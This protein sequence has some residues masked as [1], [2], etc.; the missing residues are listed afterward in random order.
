MKKY[1]LF[2]S[3][4][5]RR[6]LVLRW[7]AFVSISIF[8]TSRASAQVF[9]A[10]HAHW[11]T[12]MVISDST[13]RPLQ[14]ATVKVNNRSAGVVTDASGHFHLQVPDTCSLIVSYLG[15]QTER[16]NADD[17]A[18]GM[19]IKLKQIDQ[20]LHALTVYTGYQQLSG[21][22]ITGAYEKVGR[23][24]L[25]LEVSPDILSKL[26]GK[27]T[28]LLF[29]HRNNDQTFSIRGQS[30]IFGNTSPLII[31]NDFPYEGDLKN[32][33][34]NDI[35]SVTVLKDA[36]ATS[37]WGTRAGNGVVV[38]KTR[39]ASYNQPFRLEFSSNLT[40]ISKPNV[41]DIPYMT[42]PDYIGAEEML[43][44]KGYY[45]GQI[46]GYNHPALTP[47]VELLSKARNGEISE[48]EANAKINA[49]KKNNVKDDF[50][51]Y[52]YQ[53]GFNQQYFLTLSGGSSKLGYRISGGYDYNTDVLAAT[54]KRINIREE[55]RWNPLRHL[56][57]QTTLT[58]TSSAS[59]GGRPPYSQI[60][61]ASTKSLFPYARLA[62]DQGNPL[63]LVKDYNS[64][65]IEQAE[66]QGLLNWQ[67]Y[68]L[69]DY[70]HNRPVNRSHDLLLDASAKYHLT[71]ALS[72]SITYQYETT[73][74]PSQTLET[75]Q[76]YDGRNLIN[77]FT[78]VNPDGSLTY[79]VPKGD[80]LQW[81]HSELN[82]FAARGQINYDK[83]WRQNSFVA[84]AG[85]EIRQAH[86]ASN[87]GASYGYDPNTLT[88]TS[89]DY[90]SYFPAYYATGTTISIPDY[91]YYGDLMD[92]YVSYY[93]HGTYSYKERYTLSIS[94]RRDGSNIFGVSANQKIVPLWSAGAAW[95]LSKEPFYR[96]AW[97]PYL[98]LRLTNGFSG[99]VDN[100]LSAL[101]TIHEDPNAEYSHAVYAIIENPP[102]PSLRW[103][104]VHQLNVGVDFGVKNDRIHGSV[105]YYIKNENDLIGETPL[106]PTT[107]VRSQTVF[108]GTPFRFTG[109][110]ADMSGYGVNITLHSINLEKAFRWTT[111]LLFTYQRNKVTKYAIKPDYN[112]E[113]LN[114]GYGINP[115]VGKP[116][117]AI[118]SL[119]WAGLDPKTGDPMG[120]LKG[121]V[122]KEYSDILYNDDIADLR[123]N[124]PALPPLFGTLRNTFFYKGLSLSFSIDYKFDN[125]FVRNSISYGSL[126]GS[127]YGHPDFAKRWQKPGDEKYTNVPSMVYPNPYGRDAF[128]QSSSV[129]VTPGDCIRL[130][131]L[132]LS[133][134]LTSKAHRYRG[135][136]FKDLEISIDAKNLGLLW[137]ANKEGLDP[138]YQ[139]LRPS[140]EVAVGFRFS[141]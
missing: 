98:K 81:N 37:I 32:I 8:F 30:T 27:F 116:L 123:Y 60:K 25:D 94:G 124:G 34:P 77:E 87:S 88:Y 113:Y 47:V 26:E 65:F 91:T 64:D 23:K 133:Y 110:V 36:A 117:S 1:F 86:Q 114:A 10:F 50:S 100:K 72:A 107:G 102:N 45:N 109:N 68:P 28:G 24:T 112:D 22:Q 127:G 52:L 63:P 35:E 17:V 4:S 99:N 42:S 58:Y 31:L 38:I 74:T 78:Q 20:F 16:I 6:F 139:V 96:V 33:N 111:D 140:K 122:S 97:L 67:Y 89:V 137:K 2:M 14:G 76:S 106:D 57:I 101:T 9:K 92:R 126:Y 121:K 5:I 59:K 135:M 18:S 41:D 108:E 71:D 51:K 46:N 90:T 66:A 15:Y 53:T 7:I 141:F 70:L 40:R 12:G 43:F 93:A 84:M 120:Y 75:M 73:H 138:E 61:P 104:K 95:M 21:N 105:D 56:E 131:T 129:L 48:D 103:E 49:L 136:P 69:T 130:R 118:Y 39:D 80:V 55:N 132:D 79:P 119:P 134:E 11:I 13:L 3:P 44:N 54:Y 115:I 125:Y 29:D 128:Y 62:D 85:M 19:T 82:A 83:T